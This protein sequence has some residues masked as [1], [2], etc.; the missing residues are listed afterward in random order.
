M[1]THKPDASRLVPKKRS[2]PRLKQSMNIEQAMQTLLAQ[3][4]K[5]QPPDLIED[6]KKHDHTAT[7]LGVVHHE[8]LMPP[9]AKRFLDSKA[10]GKKPKHPQYTLDLLFPHTINGIVYGPGLV[11]V[12][13]TKLLEQLAYKDHISKE[14]ENRA[15][16]SVSRCHLIVNKVDSYGRQAAFAQPVDERY[17]NNGAALMNA[18]I[19]KEFSNSD[20]TR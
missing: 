19:F 15:F 17:F 11:S 13:T 20:I 12:T 18:P 4:F 2:P 1:E 16:E 3:G 5:I 7:A 10:Q 9:T 6:D 8:A 14:Q